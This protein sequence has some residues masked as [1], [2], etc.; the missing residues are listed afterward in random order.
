[1]R[2]RIIDGLLWLLNSRWLNKSPCQYGY[3]GNLDAFS[4][5]SLESEDKMRPGVTVRTILDEATQFKSCRLLPGLSVIEGDEIRAATLWDVHELRQAL[6]AKSDRGD[7][8][9]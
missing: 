5:E 4:R 8:R 1:M 7:T 3:I 2:S 6:T 9:Q